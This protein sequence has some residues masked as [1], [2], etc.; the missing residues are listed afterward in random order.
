VALSLAPASFQ[1][2][3]LQTG[4]ADFWVDVNT[5]LHDGEHIRLKLL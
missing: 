3:G 4:K 2:P 5:V 1:T